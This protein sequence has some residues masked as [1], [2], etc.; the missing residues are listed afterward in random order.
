MHAQ[1][2]LFYIW[3]TLRFIL[4]KMN[5][6]S[7]QRKTPHNY[8]VFQ[9][10]PLDDESSTPQ[11]L[12]MNKIHGKSWNFL[13][14]FLKMLLIRNVH[15]KPTPYVCHWDAAIWNLCS[16]GIWI[17]IG[18]QPT[19][20]AKWFCEMVLMGCHMNIPIR[21]SLLLDLIKYDWAHDCNNHNMT[22]P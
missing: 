11:Y 3:C 21:N 5:R 15:W 7:V 10:L 22:T 13:H 20:F 4:D 14:K 19:L 18:N 6:L 9:P 8:I 2:F 1:I 12:K 17:W 16:I